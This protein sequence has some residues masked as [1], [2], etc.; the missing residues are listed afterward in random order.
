MIECLDAIMSERQGSED[1]KAEFKAFNTKLDESDMFNRW[2]DSTVAIALS[3]TSIPELQE[4]IKTAMKISLK[5]GYET[6]KQEVS[7]AALEEMFR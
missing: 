7:A 6:Y 3:L 5:L 1:S 4:C 2:C